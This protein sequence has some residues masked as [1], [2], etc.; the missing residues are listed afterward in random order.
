MPLL[1]TAAH[2]LSR[3]D[4]G[5]CIERNHWRDLDAGAV[6]FE[7]H[8][9]R[10]MEERGLAPTTVAKS[11]RLLKAILQTAVDDDLLSCNPCRIKFAGKEEADERPTAT[12]EQVFDLA[13]S[14][15]P[16]RRLMVLLGAFASL[17]PEELAE[18]SRHSADLDECSL[19]IT[20]APPS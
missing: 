16:R 12:I 2:Q 4:R 13:D 1:R 19:R 3:R 18:P 20:L 9:L 10:W 6:N 17:R 7:K 8:A 15:G 14:M 11:Y 5:S